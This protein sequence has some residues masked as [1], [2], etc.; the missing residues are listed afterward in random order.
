MVWDRLGELAAIHRI[1]EE[2]IDE[3]FDDAGVEV[4]GDEG[5][6]HFDSHQSA[7][8]LLRWRA[9]RLEPVALPHFPG[10]DSID[11][12]LGLLGV[13]PQH[14]LWARCGEQLAYL[15]GAGWHS[16]TLP[17]AMD[18]IAGIEQG[19]IWIVAEA[20]S[21]L[22]SRG[23]DGTWTRTPYV[24]ERP[25]SEDVG[26]D[27]P[28]VTLRVDSRGEPWLI[29]EFIHGSKPRIGNLLHGISY[30]YTIRPIERTNPCR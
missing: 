5:Y 8:Q 17:R 14:R 21:A 27:E 10:R 4:D 28:W 24:A 16:E 20:D 26:E 9:G 18:G 11:G 6:V 13:D 1:T 30:V 3:A 12:C 2:V 15:D 7:P 23:E 22:W 25:G 19:R 29:R